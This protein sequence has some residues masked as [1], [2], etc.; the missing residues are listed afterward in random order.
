MPT[1]ER[2]G[3]YQEIVMEH[4]ISDGFDRII[5]GGIDVCPLSVQLYDVPSVCRAPENMTCE[6]KISHHMVK[7]RRIGLA[8][9][10]FTV[11][12]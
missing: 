12:E 3:R 2:V 8:Y 9:R 5:P 10:I 1:L 4:R 6:P 7:R 11:A